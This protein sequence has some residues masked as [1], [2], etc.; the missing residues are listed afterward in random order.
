MANVARSWVSPVLIAS[1]AAASLAVYGD[2]PARVHLSLDLL[3]LSASEPARAAAR[4]LVLFGIPVLTLIVWA[5][6]RA[7]PTAG[8]QRIGRRMFRSAPED[9]T[10]PETFERFGKTYDAIV[11][12]VVLLLIGMHAAVLLAL[13]GYNAAASRVI[14]VVIGASLAFMGNVMPRLRPNW[15][16]GLRS[17]RLLNDPMLWRTAHRAFGTAFVIGGLVTMVVGLIAP[18]F[19]VLTG[20]ASVAVSCVVGFIASTRPSV[21][22]P[23]ATQQR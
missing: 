8:G 9:V 1:A 22:S 15:V 4:E 6:F 16:A 7:A 18:R 3:P 21:S 19:G 2:V 11:L 14:P 10:R 17:K 12:A 23:S 13:L 5:A 20:I